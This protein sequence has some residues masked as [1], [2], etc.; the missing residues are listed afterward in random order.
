MNLLFIGGTGNISLAC[1]KRALARGHSVAFLNRGNRPELT[2]EGVETLKADIRDLDGARAAI[3][4]RR[5]DAV[6]D[7][8]A[9]T[10]PHAESDYAL[11]RDATGQFVFVS[12]A[13]IYRKPPNH[14]IITEAT[15]RFNPYWQYSRDK[16]ACEDWLMGKHRGEGFP[17]TVVRPS[18]TYSEGWFPTSFGSTGFT[19]PSRILSGDPIVV[20]GDGTSL[21]TLTHAEDFARA[22]VDLLGNP[23]AVGESFHITSEE[24]LSWD[25][26][27]RT[28][29]QAL[30]REPNIV[31]IPSDFIARVSPKRGAEL[32]GDKAPCAVFDNSKIKRF[33]PNYANLIPFHEGMRRSAA[34]IDARPGLKVR[35]PAVDAEIEAVLAA[36]DGKRT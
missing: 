30:G 5:F 35:D 26:I 15:D 3:G 29:A 7:W 9:F 4:K 27:H 17:V 6:V 16:I 20:H 33:A 1:A 36:W 25:Q 8:V 11:F 32:L 13:S 14:W 28:I 12:S 22:F 18:H 2:P 21:W 34:F 31:H 19:V 24:A 23:Q 10:V